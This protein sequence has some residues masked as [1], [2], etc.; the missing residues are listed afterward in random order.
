MC[1]APAAQRV[2]LS[3]SLCLPNAAQGRLVHSAEGRSPRAGAFFVPRGRFALGQHRACRPGTPRDAERSSAALSARCA[4]SPRAQPS[5]PPF[6]H[7]QVAIAAQRPPPLPRC[8]PHARVRATHLTP[9]Q[10]SARPVAPQTQPTAGSM[11]MTAV[12]SFEATVS[13][14]GC[15]RQWQGH[16]LTGLLAHRAQTN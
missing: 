9:W 15:R 5:A 3:I 4:C 14:L 16:Q 6:A 12:A 7:T 1:V 13:G 8:V 2:A 10:P 11:K